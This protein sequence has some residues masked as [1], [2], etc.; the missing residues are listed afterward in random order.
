MNRTDYNNKL[1][2]ISQ[3]NQVINEAPDKM[4][5]EVF[6]CRQYVTSLINELAQESG[7]TTLEIELEW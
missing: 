3:M 2:R 6:Q 5:D 1:N 4:T 7:K